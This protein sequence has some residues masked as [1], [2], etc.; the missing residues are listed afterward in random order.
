MV[1]RRNTT[2]DQDEDQ[3]N[4]WCVGINLVANFSA[5]TAEEAMREIGKIIQN[6]STIPI[7]MEPLYTFTQW[8]NSY[9]KMAA[10]DGNTRC[11]SF[12]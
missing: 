10:P 5:P 2:I 7:F 8:N 3:G 9:F 4:T 12:L 1:F 11:K 6:T